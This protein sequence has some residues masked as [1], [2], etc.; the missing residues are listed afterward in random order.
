MPPIQLDDAVDSLAGKPRSVAERSVVGD[1]VPESVSQSP[2]SRSV[3]MVVVVVRQQHRVDRRQICDGRQGVDKAARASELDG[4]GSLRPHG[5]CQQIE[6]RKLDDIGRMF[7]ITRERVR[8]IKEL[9]I[10]NMRLAVKNFDL[11]AFA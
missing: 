2:Y 7:N 1:L 8:Q 5:I 6:T 4:R 10:Q 9:A 11:K 3:E